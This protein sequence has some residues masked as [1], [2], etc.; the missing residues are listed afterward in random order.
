[1][2]LSEFYPS[3]DDLIKSEIAVLNY[4]RDEPYI[5]DKHSQFARDASKYYDQNRNLRSGFAFNSYFDLLHAPMHRNKTARGRQGGRTPNARLMVSALIELDNGAFSNVTYCLA[6]L[7]I[8]FNRF[9]LLRKFHFDVVSKGDSSQRRL[10]EH[11]RSHLQYCGGMVP[12]MATM[13]CRQTQLDQMYPWLSEPRIFFWPMALALLIDMALHE[14]PDPRSAKFRKN[15]EWRG[16]VRRQEVLVLRRFYKKC[17]DVIDDTRSR[18][19]T[20]ADEFYVG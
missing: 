7:R 9:T 8:R 5:N 16:L 6:I 10:Q 19:L 14:F 2:D 20:L 13:G 12:G 18:N 15:P 4:L 11:P 3:P 1:L 17:V